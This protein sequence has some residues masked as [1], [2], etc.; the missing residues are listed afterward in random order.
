MFA[1]VLVFLVL[2]EDL[3]LFCAPNLLSRRNSAHSPLVL[4]DDAALHTQVKDVDI[5]AGKL[6][7]GNTAFEEQIELGEGPASR[8]WNAEVGVDDAAKT[9]AGPEEAGIIAP[10][11]FCRV[12]C[13]SVVVPGLSQGLYLPACMV[14]A[15]CR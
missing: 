4:V 12:L 5:R 15:H 8:F 14:S 13:M 1:V 3:P 2:S 10:V 9:D 6:A 7:R 11:P